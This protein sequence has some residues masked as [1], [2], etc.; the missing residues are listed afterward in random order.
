ML[1]RIPRLGLLER[2]FSSNIVEVD[3]AYGFPQESVRWVTGPL[4]GAV[5]YH[6]VT[7]ISY[8]RRRSV[9]DG[10]AA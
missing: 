5:L 3:T 2:L 8:R 1:S 4:Q 10:P 6:T 9:S 7:C